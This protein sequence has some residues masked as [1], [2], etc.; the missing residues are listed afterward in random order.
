MSR[1]DA[2]WL[3]VV[4]GLIAP[5]GCS[6]L[7]ETRSVTRFTGAFEDRDISALRDAT[8]TEFQKRALRDK[9]A[10][11]AMDL[12]ELPE[13]KVSVAEVEEVSVYDWRTDDRL[14]AVLAVGEPRGH[15][16][17]DTGD[18]YPVMVE[19][20]ATGQ[21]KVQNHYRGNARRWCFNP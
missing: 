9:S 15:F 16:D 19:K 2:A 6:H 14:R 17:L 20:L 3:A 11:E 8:S 21:R 5:A 7:V 10:V 18:M 13:G 4:L 12:L 1:R